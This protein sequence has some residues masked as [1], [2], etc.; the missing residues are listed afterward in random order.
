MSADHFDDD[1]NSHSDHDSD[2]DSDG[3][4]YDAEND[5]H[6]LKKNTKKSSVKVAELPDEM[7]EKIC[8]YLSQKDITSLLSTDKKTSQLHQ[9]FNLQSRREL[10]Q[11]LYEF[12]YYKIN[13]QL[14]IFEDDAKLQNINFENLTI[15][16]EY[17]TKDSP[18]IIKINNRNKPIYL[19]ITRNY[20]MITRVDYENIFDENYS[21]LWKK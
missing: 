9:E 17:L 12:P 21:Y 8:Y 1:Y 7:L 6:R 13:Y 19:V 5:I 20:F 11:K 10:S 3:S 15:S 16:N 2:Y 4:Y 18:I 14:Y